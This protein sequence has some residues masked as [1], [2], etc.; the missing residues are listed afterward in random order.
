MLPR[1]WL[2]VG[3][4]R[5]TDRPT[6]RQCHLLSCPGQLKKVTSFKIFILTFSLSPNGQ[7]VNSFE[8]LVLFQSKVCLDNFYYGAVTRQ[9]YNHR[10]MVQD[11][12]GWRLIT[13]QSSAAGI[14][15]DINQRENGYD[16]VI[17]SERSRAI[18]IWWHLSKSCTRKGILLYDSPQIFFHNFF[19]PNL[20]FQKENE[21]EGGFYQAL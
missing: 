19:E 2:L 16:R 13:R 17:L 1:L 9:T 14:Y 20:R 7:A 8:F 18:L 10:W 21:E 11:G 3:S 5:P 15:E 6:D 12:M 4:D